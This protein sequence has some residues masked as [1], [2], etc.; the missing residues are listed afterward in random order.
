MSPKKKSK[1]NAEIFADTKKSAT[2]A[3][4]IEKQTML[5]KNDGGIAQLVR[6]HDS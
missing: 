1:K 2:F 6:A 5:K 3:P 4:A